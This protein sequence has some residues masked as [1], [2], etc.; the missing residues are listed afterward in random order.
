MTNPERNPLLS[1]VRR[2]KDLDEAE[3]TCYMDEITKVIGSVAQSSL[4][5]HF[6]GGDLISREV[7][8]MQ[9]WD[10]LEGT[11]DHTATPG[12][13]QGI[14]HLLMEKSVTHFSNDAMVKG[15]LRKSFENLLLEGEARRS[16]EY[17]SRKKQV[18]R[19]LKT[20]CIKRPVEK[21]EY[22]KEHSSQY[23]DRHRAVWILRSKTF[24]D[25]DDTEGA[26]ASKTSNTSKVF[27]G[28]KGEASFGD[29]A[30]ADETLSMDAPYRGDIPDSDTI[31]RIAA[32][33]PLP[34]K[35]YA[36]KES[37]RRGTEI[38]ERDMAR[39]LETLMERAGGVIHVGDIDARVREMVGAPTPGHLSMDTPTLED[40]DPI[41][42][43]EHALFKKQRDELMPSPEH[44]LMADQILSR[45]PDRFKTLLDGLFVKGMTQGEV[46]GKMGVS[47]AGI[48]NMK[49]ELTRYMQRAMTE[50]DDKMSREEGEIVSRL[51]IERI[52]D[53]FK[54][55]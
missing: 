49:G 33:I 24:P 54:E 5:E 23:R 22:K 37:A 21:R 40:D 9:C 12:G 43:A 26:N 19:V 16:P 18:N 8:E 7:F 39:Y 30:H 31:C 45:M 41:D 1:L 15:Y 36:A 13:R 14:I 2:R 11:D 10:L 48:S 47:D 28:S 29:A 3:L 17:T 6:H 34:E 20:F 46:A 44:L 38:K 50:N 4:F 55:R 51:I 42:P 53:E 32:T 27:K 52:H 25:V 35:R